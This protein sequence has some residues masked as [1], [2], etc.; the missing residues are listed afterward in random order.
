MGAM[1]EPRRQHPAQRRIS[2]RIGAIAESATLKVDAKAKALKA[3]G[4]PVI[5]FG[6]GRARLPDA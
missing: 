4:R 1:T 5:G 3:E 6:A 2:G